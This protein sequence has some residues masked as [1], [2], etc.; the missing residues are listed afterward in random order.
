MIKISLQSMTLV[1]ALGLMA[2]CEHTRRQDSSTQ[3]EKS[4]KPSASATT[5]SEER[6]SG[7]R[8]QM[9]ID[10]IFAGQPANSYTDADVNAV[11][12]NYGVTRQTDRNLTI[13]ERKIVEYLDASNASILRQDPDDFETLYVAINKG[14]SPY[15]LAAAVVP[16]D[17]DTV[18]SEACSEGGMSP[19]VCSGMGF[20][21]NRTICVGDDEE[22]VADFT[23]SFVNDDM[24]GYNGPPFPEYSLLITSGK[25]SEN[26]RKALAARNGIDLANL[27]GASLS[28]DES[29]V[30]TSE[31]VSDYENLGFDCQRGFPSTLFNLNA[32]D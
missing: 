27:D 30:F 8:R 15:D 20:S 29:R 1:L 28:E 11:C 23:S 4:A 7:W 10:D 5:A 24:V 32:S 21:S 16:Y 26:M 25:Y 19:Y 31:Y 3:S 22:I 6:I 9:C 17:F 12:E 14:V 2:S 18:F 13:M